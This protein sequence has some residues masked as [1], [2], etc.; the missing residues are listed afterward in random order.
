[1]NHDQTILQLEQ[2]IE[3]QEDKIFQLLNIVTATNRKVVELKVMVE[4]ATY[5]QVKRI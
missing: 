5:G 3:A 2:R 1:M 4:E